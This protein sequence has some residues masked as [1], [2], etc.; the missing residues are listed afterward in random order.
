MFSHRLTALCALWI[1]ALTLLRATEI[2]R[3]PFLTVTFYYSSFLISFLVLAIFDLKK[4]KFNLYWLPFYI[5]AVIS[6]VSGAPSAFFRPWERYVSFCV[7]TFAIGP[8]IES[9]LL[10]EFRKKNIF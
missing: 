9:P 2:L 1:S 8:L 4:I 10:I 5:F 3:P 7:I 6:I